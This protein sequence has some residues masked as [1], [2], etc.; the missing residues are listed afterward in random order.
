MI[1]KNIKFIMALA[2]TAVVLVSCDREKVLAATEIP[3]EIT[4]M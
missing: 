3:G 1:R 4:N 2:I